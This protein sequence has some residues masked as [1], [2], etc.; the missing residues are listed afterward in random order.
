MEEKARILVRQTMA[1]D[2]NAHRECYDCVKEVL[3]ATCCKFTLSLS[4]GL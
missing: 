4:S 1:T 3:E 2:I